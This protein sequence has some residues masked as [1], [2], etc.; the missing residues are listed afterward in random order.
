MWLKK[1]IIDCIV[2]IGLYVIVQYVWEI[3]RKIIH[4][5]VRE[6]EQMCV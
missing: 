1:S 2:C 4:V 6:K 5:V 3:G